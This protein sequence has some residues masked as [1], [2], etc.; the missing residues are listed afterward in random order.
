MSSYLWW[1][2]TQ[3]AGKTSSWVAA[4]PAEA[5]LIAAA[6]ANP[7]TRKFTLDVL[8]IVVRE[9]IRSWANITR[10][11]G[12][13]LVNRSTVVARGAQY[14]V[15]A[16]AALLSRAQAFS[17]IPY[18]VPVTVALTGRGI[19]QAEGFYGGRGTPQDPAVQQNVSL[20][21]NLITLGKMR[22]G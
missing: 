21:S 8:K 13:S 4:N 1:I 19:L 10:G 11:I 20:I 12:Q 6:L 14:A 2:G 16:R 15:S 22:L 3:V 7:A 5:S 18:A 17:R 9:N